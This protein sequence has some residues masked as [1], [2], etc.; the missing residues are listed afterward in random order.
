MFCSHCALFCNI[1]DYIVQGTT[2]V[3]LPDQNDTDFTKTVQHLLT[4]RKSGELKVSCTEKLG[5]SDF[6]KSYRSPYQSQLY[7]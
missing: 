1:A 4:L 3:R 6:L 2:T 5:M 7:H